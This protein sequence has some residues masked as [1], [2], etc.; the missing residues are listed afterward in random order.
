MKEQQRKDK[1]LET[2]EQAG[3]RVVLDHHNQTAYVEM[4]QEGDDGHTDVAKE[5]LPIMA[6]YSERSLSGKLRHDN[7]RQP[8]QTAK[9]FLHMTESARPCF[10]RDFEEVGLIMKEDV[11]QMA[12]DRRYKRLAGSKKQIEDIS[13]PSSG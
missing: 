12:A 3:V 4:E 6:E 13:K 2:V 1:A 5:E 9:A 11:A 7:I 10:P 8:D